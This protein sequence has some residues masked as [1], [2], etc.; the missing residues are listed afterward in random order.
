V[1]L[2]A[3]GRVSMGN[4]GL[5][6]GR[7]VDNMD[8]TEWALLGTDTATDAQSL[9]D[10]SNFRFGGDFDTELAGSDNRARFLAFLTAFLRTISK[11]TSMENW[12]Y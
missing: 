6:V 1:E 8:C 11:F 5:E 4:L 2:E 7:Q 12:K 10:E 3:V 9:R